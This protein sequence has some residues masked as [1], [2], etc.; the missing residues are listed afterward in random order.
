MD[1]IFI[2]SDKLVRLD[3]FLAK[4][5][6]RRQAKRLIKESKVYVE[7]RL[8]NKPSYVIKIGDRIRIEENK[9]DFFIKKDE[10]EIIRETEAF[11][12]IAKPGFL[13]SVEGRHKN[14]LEYWL[15]EQNKKVFLLNRL[16]FLTSGIVLGAKEKTAVEK[17]HSWQEQGRVHK[18]YLAKVR[19]VVEAKKVI[20]Y[21][22]DDN[23]RKKVRVFSKLTQDPLRYTWVYPVTKQKDTSLLLVKILK[24]KRHQI[25]AHLAYLGFPIVGDLLYGER[26]EFL[27]LHHFYLKSPEFFV[28]NWPKWLTVVEQEKVKD[29]LN[30]LEEKGVVNGQSG[31]PFSF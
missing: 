20:Q 17:Y 9:E 22:I 21:H 23:K 19:G 4:F 28:F 18:Y 24:G 14:N 15:K 31:C 1:K 11:I 7:G 30:S 8:I 27:Y 10:I 2:C 5:F 26:E 16:D 6:S 29:I 12:A 25:R 13:H 3:I